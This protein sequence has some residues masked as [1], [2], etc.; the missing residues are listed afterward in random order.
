MTAAINLES[1]SWSGCDCPDVRGAHRRLPGRRHAG[2][3]L[4][5]DYVLRMAR[6][7]NSGARFAVWFSALMAM[8]ALPLLAGAAWADGASTSTATLNEAGNHAAGLVGALAIRRVG[9][10][11]CVW[12]GAGG[13]GFMASARDTAELRR[14]RYGVAGPGAARNTGMSRVSGGIGEG[15]G[16]LRSAS[17]IGSAFLR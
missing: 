3:V 1:Q 12:F 13:C 10:N 4:L 7:W 9:W 11:R 14:S 15:S 8:A 6:R 5:P 2:R 16:Q 17:P